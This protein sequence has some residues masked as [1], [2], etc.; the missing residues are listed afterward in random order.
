MDLKTMKRKPEAETAGVKVELPCGLIVQVRHPDNLD[1]RKL[2]QQQLLRHRALYAVGKA[3]AAD[4]VQTERIELVVETVLVNWF[5]LQSEGKD[6]PFSKDTA[7]KVLA[8][9][10]DILTEIEAMVSAPGLFLASQRED[11][12]KN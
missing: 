10:P 5:G 11:E 6:L 4:V 2:R 3:P 9:Y 1:A 7:Y 12:A 8:E